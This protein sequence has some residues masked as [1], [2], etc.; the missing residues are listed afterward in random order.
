MRCI[1]N[2]KAFLF[3]GKI[4]FKSVFSINYMSLSQGCPN[5]CFDF[6]RFFFSNFDLEIFETET[7]ILLR[8]FSN[9]NF[10]H[11]CLIQ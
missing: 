2:W 8:R 5:F 7:L 11:L 1:F 9:Q 10:L 4:F 3:I 6:E